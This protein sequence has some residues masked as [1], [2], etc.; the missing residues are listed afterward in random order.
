[1]HQFRWL[2]ERGGKFLNLLQKEEVP[3]KGGVPSEE[4]GGFQV[5]VKLCILL[6]LLSGP[7]AKHIL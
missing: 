7:L 6:I 3:K 2:S 5:W 4:Q 1:M